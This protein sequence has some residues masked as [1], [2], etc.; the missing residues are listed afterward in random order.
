MVRY[1]GFRY[2]HGS[3]G[4][5]IMYLHSVALFFPLTSSPFPYTLPPHPTTYAH[6]YLLVCPQADSERKSIWTSGRERYLPPHL[7][8]AD[9]EPGRVPEEEISLRRKKKHLTEL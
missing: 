4:C 8:P 6:A 1:D 9:L 2:M 7:L 5:W 3:D